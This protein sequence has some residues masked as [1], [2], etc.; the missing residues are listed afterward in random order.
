MSRRGRDYLGN[1][2]SIAILKIYLSYPLSIIHLHLL[3]L[4]LLLV[5]RFKPVLRP[6]FRIV[7]EDRE[8][9][10][11]PQSRVLVPRLPHLLE[12][13]GHSVIQKECNQLQ[14]CEL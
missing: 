8:K 1:R 12:W 9:N 13:V 10:E 7:V 3:L 6:L 5:D 14:S 2:I 4:L 11:V